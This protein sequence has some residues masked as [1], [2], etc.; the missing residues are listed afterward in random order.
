MFR[1]DPKVHREGIPNGVRQAS[2]TL[3]VGTRV[4]S[5]NAK[6]SFTLPG[7][8]KLVLVHRK[9]GSVS[10]GVWGAIGALT[11]AEIVVAVVM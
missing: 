2:S 1:V 9:R 4:L 5:K 11:V 7:L 3:G 10:T 6:N 8:G